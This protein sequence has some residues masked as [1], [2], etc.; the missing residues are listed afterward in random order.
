MG[1]SWTP[2]QIL[3]AVIAVGVLIAWHEF[4]HY[5]LA[6]LTGMRVLRFSVG[7]GP[8]LFST[9]KNGIEYRLGAFPLGGFVQIFGM[10]PLEEN[11][12]QDPKSFIN[13]PL[14][15]RMAVIGAG[16]IFNYALALVLFFGVF[17]VF[18][19]GNELMIRV[20]EVVTPSAAAEAGMQPGDLIISLD[21]KALKSPQ[22]FIE[23]IQSK[24]DEPMH[25]Q[26]L[27]TKETKAADSEKPNEKKQERV[28]LQITPLVDAGG[29][30]RLGIRYVPLAF[31]FGGAVE[32]S[33]RQ[34]WV[35]SVG[36][37][38]ALSKLFIDDEEEVQVGGIVEI[39][40]QLTQAA[41]RGIRDL[42]WITGC[43]SVVLGL[44]NLLPIP[45]LDGSKI[46]FMSIEA[47][48]RRE[49]NPMIQLWINAAGLLILLGL[50]LWLTVFD[51]M[52]WIADS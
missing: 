20:T 52:R 4:G 5:L 33:F 13:Q 15:A 35:Q 24:S 1:V 21:G 17:W 40:R 11:A 19:S 16:P 30:P 38:V 37:L 49:F 41:E 31:S 6:R 26:I 45:A 46:L 43:L 23:R 51:V 7:F 50:M 32:E 47:I 10:T 29:I 27:R 14:W 42:L 44:F 3:L 34:V 9:R 25:L 22:A 48:F 39:T 12:R 28:D 36:I 18:S 2:T 8:T